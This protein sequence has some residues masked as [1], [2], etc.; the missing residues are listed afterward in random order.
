MH[1]VQD[2]NHAPCGMQPTSV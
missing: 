1:Q 2:I